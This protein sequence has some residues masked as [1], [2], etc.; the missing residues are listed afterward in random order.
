MKRRQAQPKPIPFDRYAVVKSVDAR[1]GVTWA[2][3]FYETEPLANARARTV[4]AM[5]GHPAVKVVA[6]KGCSG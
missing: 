4:N 2:E 3:E 6:K 1:A 5:L